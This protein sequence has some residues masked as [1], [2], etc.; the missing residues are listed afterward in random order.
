[1]F[2]QPPGQERL[3]SEAA[4]IYALAAY[5][6]GMPAWNFPEGLARRVPAG[7]KLVF[8]LH[9]TPNGAEQVDLSEAGL[10]FADPDEVEKELHIGA[11]YNF[12]FQIPPGEPNY[13]VR[14][15]RRLGQDVII[16]ALLPHMHLRGKSFRFD[17]RYPDGRREPLLHVPRYDFNWQNAY[18]FE[19]PKRVPEGTVLE[20]VAHFDNSA[21][22]PV[23]P[24]PKALVLW[25]DQTW[26]EMMVGSYDWVLADQ[27]L[28][29]GR[30]TATRRDDG[31]FDV[32]FR[33]RPAA[34]ARSVHLAGSFN[35]WNT[36]AQALEG[37]DS[38]G[39][40]AVTVT[41]D[42]GAYEYKFVVDGNQWRHDPGNPDH[43]GYYHN[44]VLR[45]GP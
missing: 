6:P 40:Y 21:A 39:R 18:A 17:L 24:D 44:S 33:Y 26:Q 22:N 2:Y 23:N 10:V 43:A 36:S 41:L 32:R 8:Q 45:V 1:L 3:N 16:S 34:G 9:Y 7:S 31:R 35:D 27:D 28:R 19:E 4:L 15:E 14:A 25:G 13:E 38:E 29:L 30:P 20:C 11:V 5:A 37:P 42:P 12:Q